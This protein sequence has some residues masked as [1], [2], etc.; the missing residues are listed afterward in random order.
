MRT[1]RG[2]GACSVQGCLLRVS[3]GAANCIPTGGI[4]PYH[5]KLSDE[6]AASQKL[7]ASRGGRAPRNGCDQPSKRR[8]ST[9]ALWPPKPKELLI[10]ISTRCSRGLFGT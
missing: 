10:A 4:D 9:V 8:T 1:R 7:P 6:T 3:T 5:A 2:G